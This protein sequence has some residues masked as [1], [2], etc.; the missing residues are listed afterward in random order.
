MLKL[1]A[2]LLRHRLGSATATL[3]ALAVGVMILTAM[4][5]VVESGLRHRPEPQR[6]AAADVVLAHRTMTV[7]GKDLDG[8][9]VR[10]T[11]ALPEGGTVPADLAGRV[12]RVPGV[13]AAIPD[14]TVPVSLAGGPA[15]GRG[16]GSAVLTPFR[17]VAGNEPRDADEIVVEGDLGAVGTRVDLLVGGVSRAFRISGVAERATSADGPPAIFFTDARAA[18]LTAR[19]GRADAVGILVADGADR[20][21]VLGAARRL[22]DEAGVTAY[23][24]DDRG[25]AEQPGA[26]G[27]AGTLLVQIGASFGGYVALLIVFVVAGTVGL[28]VRHRRRDLALLR[29][30]AATPGQ[31][32]RMIVAEAALVSLVAAAVGLPAGVF[33]TGWIRGEMVARGLVP[34]GFPIRVWPLAAASAVLLIVVAAMLAA[35]IAA[36]RTA[37]I[38]PVEALGETAV[39]PAR[40]GKVRFGFGVA[41]LAGAGSLTVFT[42]AADGQAAIGAA[43][44]LLYLFVLAVALLAPWINRAAAR[45]T[46]PV[47]RAV[48]RQSGYLAERNLQAHARGMTTVLTALVLSVGFGGSVWFLQDNLQRQTVAQSRDGMLADR[49]LV[50]PA[51][52][53]ASAADAARRLPGVAGVT[54][55]RQTSVLVRFLDSAEPV[56]AQGVDPRGLTE[57]MDLKVTD[58]SLADLGPTGVAV[59]GV[60]AATLGWQ[61][62]EQVTLWLGDGTPAELR[63]VAL[64]DRGLGF[65]DVVL[66]RA[67]IAGHTATGLDD[68]VLIRAAPGADLDAELTAL[69]ARHPG[70]TVLDAQALT[71]G[72]KGDLAVSAWLNKLLIGVMVGYAALAAANTMVMAALA[73]RRELSL[74]RLVGVTRRQVKRMVHAEQ[75]GLLG[76]AL[77]IGAAIAGITLSS[78]VNAL[79]G[80]PVPYVPVLGFVVVI[81]GATLLALTTTVLPVGR[82]LRVPPVESIGI[83]E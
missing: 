69:A 57:T 27:S 11:V 15:E 5:A 42:T 24:G 34:D 33:A 45:V 52:L 63:V 23:A 72:L 26:A 22:A 13:A 80:H 51:G 68:R 76:T 54:G 78:V 37:R 58:G 48:W 36:R 3:I 41:A 9:V 8:S 56:A 7:T 32:R 60:Q 53:P 73:R 35:L 79:T 70:S 71:R 65:G 77:L 47:L 81:G 19:P 21:A 14:T 38:R 4:G 29:A 82:L 39:E 44:G 40:N 64:Y 20:T 75:I 18:A 83:K 55:V 43:V 6:Y 28:S 17:I 59:S 49:A 74:L 31:I 30:V 10:S 46:G 61:V 1:A 50:A 25:L 66:D 12:A 16:W 67:T 62:G 2:K